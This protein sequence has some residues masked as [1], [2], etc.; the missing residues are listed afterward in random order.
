MGSD[1]LSKLYL[2]NLDAGDETLITESDIQF[3]EFYETLVNHQWLV[4][5]ETDHGTKNYIM[6][7]NRS[8]GKSKQTPVV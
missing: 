5:L 3:G 1:V 7:M 2:Y 4:W 8:T 6:V